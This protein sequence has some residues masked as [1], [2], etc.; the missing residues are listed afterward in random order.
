MSND[1]KSPA[2]KKLLDSLQ[3]Q[4]WELELIISGFA[5]FGLFTIYEPLKAEMLNAE[6]NE[7]IF[8]FVINLVALIACS[9]L[10]FNLL[11]HVV[12]RGVWIGALGLRYVSGD[13]DFDVLKYGD[14]FKNYLRKRIVSFD[15]YIANLENSCSVLFAL[16][17]LTIF[18][19]LGLT[20]IILSISLV[21]NYIIDN[22]NIPDWISNFV[23]IPLTVFLAIGMFLT[24]IDFV[25]LGLLKRNKW[26]ALVYFP[27]YWVFSYISLSFLYRPLLYNFLD[28]KFGK[29]LIV[30]LT[31]IYIIILVLTGLEYRNSNYFSAEL[32]SRSYVA[33]KE[34]YR[35]Q[36]TKTSDIPAQITIPSK[37]IRTPYLNTFIGFSESIEDRIIS[38]NDSLKPEKDLRGLISN[39]FNFGSSDW[40]DRIRNKD[41]VRQAYIKT[42][43]E[44]Y[45]FEIDT[46]KFAGDFTISTDNKAN[47]GFE[48]YLNI[49]ELNEGKHILRLIRKQ[50]NNGEIIESRRA[51]IP[52]W[53]YKEN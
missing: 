52:F 27:F 47:I 30:F 35:D 50:K 33:N 44:I 14:K 12:L 41:S 6:N 37:V 26:V 38:F 4:S 24:F 3:Q 20:L 2:F 17:F 5:I 36:L 53:Y 9:I 22:E 1:Y 32:S 40:F 19:V 23:G 18:F 45:S 34:N 21:A 28:N 10:I 11:L 43:N 49:K 7:Q 29:R 25:S 46:L 39:N 31:P 42:F 13:I 15:R 48:M 51:A 16:S 8:S